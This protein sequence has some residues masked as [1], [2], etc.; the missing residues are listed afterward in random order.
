MIKTVVAFDNAI[1]ILHG[2]KIPR[3]Y[4]WGSFLQHTFIGLLNSG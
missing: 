3:W 2:Y 4:L 1:T